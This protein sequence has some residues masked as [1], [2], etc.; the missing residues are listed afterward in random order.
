MFHATDETC[1]KLL[2]VVDGGSGSRRTYVRHTQRVYVLLK[3]VCDH[4][5][6]TKRLSGLKTSSVTFIKAKD[7]LFNVVLMVFADHLN[8]QTHVTSP[9]KIGESLEFNV[10]TF[11][12]LLYYI[13]SRLCLPYSANI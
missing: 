2:C 9:M 8:V 13:N 5:S 12:I 4:V 7:I 11:A 1:R 3:E 10:S 6:D